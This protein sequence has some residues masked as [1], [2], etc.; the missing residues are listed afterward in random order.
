MPHLIQKINLGWESAVV[1]ICK[2]CGKQFQDQKAQ[3]APEQIKSKL[4]AKVKTEL[5]KQVRVITT[6]CL[7]VCPEDKIVIVL[8]SRKDPAVFKSYSVASE[9]NTEELYKVIFNNE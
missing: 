8:A 1:M 2:N 4:K 6:S 5:G 3:E 7:G 9:V